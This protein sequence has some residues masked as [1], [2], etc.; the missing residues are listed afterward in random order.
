[1]ATQARHRT[2]TDPHDDTDHPD[3]AHTHAHTRQRPTRARTTV[4]P[5]GALHVVGPGRY[6]PAEPF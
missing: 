2:D 6:T 1:M 4:L 5:G 3:Q